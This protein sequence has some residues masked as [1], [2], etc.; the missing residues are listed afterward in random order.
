MSESKE[1]NILAIESSCDET[2]AA[3]VRNGREVRH[4]HDEHLDKRDLAL[5]EV[6]HAQTRAD[7]A[8]DQEQ[9]EVV[10]HERDVAQPLVENAIKHGI[11]P[12]EKGGVILMRLAKSKKFY[13][14]FVIDNGV[15]ISTDKQKDLL[16]DSPERQSIGLV[17]VHKR[18]VSIYGSESG[19][20]I[21]S[22]EGHGTN[23]SFKIPLKGA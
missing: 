5:V 20:N 16:S 12:K 10:V 22:K 14:L 6:A 8:E 13:E 9:R 23:I 17:N 15:G 7:D 3:V 18:L 19:L 2:A 1:I 4:P 11:L 21:K